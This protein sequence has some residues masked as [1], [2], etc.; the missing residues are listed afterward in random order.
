MID[1]GEHREELLNIRNGEWSFQQI[2][3][4]ALE[5]DQDFQTAF[6]QTSLPDQPDFAVVDDFLIRARRSA[7]ESNEK[8]T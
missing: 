6:D 5:L 3:D 4:R 2:Q 8:E 7:V 1:V